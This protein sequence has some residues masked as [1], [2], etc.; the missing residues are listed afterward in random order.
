MTDGSYQ[1]CYQT[2]Y[3]LSINSLYPTVTDVRPK[4]APGPAPA[5]PLGSGPRSGDSAGWVPPPSRGCRNRRVYYLLPYLTYLGAGLAKPTSYRQAQAGVAVR[6]LAPARGKHL[7][8]LRLAVVYSCGGS[9]E[10]RSPLS[11]TVGSE[12]SQR[13][14]TLT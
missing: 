3:S 10:T 6:V 4:T 5:L 8:S 12:T 13:W 1:T 14:P 11:A 2:L 9:A 7:L